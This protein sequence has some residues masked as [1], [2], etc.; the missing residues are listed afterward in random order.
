MLFSSFVDVLDDHGLNVF[1]E[2]MKVTHHG[3]LRMG[4]TALEQ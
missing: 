3:G 4:M 1:I 2:L